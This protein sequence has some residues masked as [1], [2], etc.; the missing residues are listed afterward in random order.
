MET[1]SLETASTTTKSVV[2]F[3]LP[4]PWGK[5]TIFHKVSTGARPIVWHRDADFGRF[6]RQ[7]GIRLCW[8]FSMSRR[9]RSVV[10]GFELDSGF[11]A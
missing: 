2:F 10:V 8:A 4:L 6:Y 11:E 3:G 5:S 7:F 1:G 9:L